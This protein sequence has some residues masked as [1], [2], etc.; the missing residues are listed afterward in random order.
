MSKTAKIV[1]CVHWSQSPIGACGV[2]LYVTLTLWA[3]T[4]KLKGINSVREVLLLLHRGQ[5]TMHLEANQKHTTIL[6]SAQQDPTRPR[7]SQQTDTICRFMLL[8]W[9]LGILVL[10]FG[11]VEGS[12][13]LLN[14]L[15]PRCTWEVQ[16]RPAQK[17]PK[18]LE[19]WQPSLDAAN[20]SMISI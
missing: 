20:I 1:S 2:Y 3:E 19:S 14:F 10:L 17:K 12:S 4:C 8:T 18:R 11:K 5:K 13:T 7:D 6:T 15:V 9:H 16:G